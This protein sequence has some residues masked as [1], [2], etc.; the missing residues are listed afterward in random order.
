M[1][2]HLTG[3]ELDLVRKWYAQSKVPTKVHA[4]LVTHREKRGTP[5]PH[6]TN[7]RKVLK[8]DT[9]RPSSVPVASQ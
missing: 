4:R 1:A 9:Y 3:A 7:F 5:A 8:G 6:L 2:P